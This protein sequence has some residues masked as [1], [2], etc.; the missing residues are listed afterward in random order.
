MS[1]KPLN[2]NLNTTDS[3]S[4]VDGT[5]SG[6]INLA[7]GSEFNTA[8]TYVNSTS[9]T[10]IMGFRYNGSEK[11][12]ITFTS[13]EPKVINMSLGSIT[14]GQRWGYFYSAKG[15]FS[16]TLDTEVGG[17]NRLFNLGSDAD[18]AAGDTE[19]LETS[20]DTNV[21]TIASVATGTG[22]QRNIEIDAPDVSFS[23]TV[24]TGVIDH[25]T[26]TELKTNGSSKMSVTAGYVRA[27]VDF[28]PT[29]DGTV[30]LGKTDYR[31]EK[32]WSVDGDFSGDV[33]MAANV[34]FTGVPTTD[35]EVAGRLWND[36]GS[37][38]ISAGSPP[39]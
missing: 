27:W 19:Y 24:T 30:E 2:Q 28:R 1:Y 15:S 37:V 20:F 13:F 10:P 12:R 5:F 32:T 7:V 35:P 38:K 34:D 8:G 16:G 4:F 21:A 36:S 39:P 25:P 33:I 14:S 6:D 9:A 3:P 22:V 29:Y 18:V 31:W 23:G 11:M 26:N 17:S